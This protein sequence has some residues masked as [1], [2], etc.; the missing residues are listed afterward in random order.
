M[1][2]FDKVAEPLTKPIIPPTTESEVVIAVVV[3]VA[4]MDV[5]AKDELLMLVVLVPARPINPPT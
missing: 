4:E 5:P 1:L 2:V 3:P